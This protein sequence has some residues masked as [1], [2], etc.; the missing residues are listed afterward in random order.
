MSQGDRALL[1][2]AI[3]AIDCIVIFDEETPARLI[4]TVLPD[5]LV[6]GGDYIAEDIV[7]YKTVTKNGGRVEVVNY[8]EGKSTT[9]IVNLIM[10]KA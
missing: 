8:I 9:G 3:E 4:E 5:V 1:L 7:G 10:E 2:S 6:K